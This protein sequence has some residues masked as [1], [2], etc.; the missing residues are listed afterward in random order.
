MRGKKSELKSDPVKLVASGTVIERSE[1]SDQGRDLDSWKGSIASRVHQST[2]SK[3][4]LGNNGQ[5]LESSH[6][7][8][9]EL[10]SQSALFNFQSLLLVLLLLICTCTYVRGSAPGLVD[11]NREG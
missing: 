9:S 7:A 2:Q 8:K 4:V 1:T 11:R 3:G 6:Q 10:I 5:L